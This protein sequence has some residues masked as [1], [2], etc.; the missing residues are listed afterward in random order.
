M[1]NETYGDGNWL[2]GSIILRERIRPVEMVLG[3]SPIEL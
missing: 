2:Y 3:K 1:E